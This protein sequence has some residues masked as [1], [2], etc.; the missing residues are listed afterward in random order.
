M[1]LLFVAAAVLTALAVSSAASAASSYCSPTGDYCTSTTRVT[2]TV[3]LRLTTFSFQGPIRICV[4]APTRRRV[5]KTFRLAKRGATWRTSVRWYRNFPNA[6]PGRYRVG[7]FIGPTRLGPLLD[8]VIR[9][10]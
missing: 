8:F 1:R 10:D 2:G 5:C 6:G 3:L 7:F 9:G 4:T